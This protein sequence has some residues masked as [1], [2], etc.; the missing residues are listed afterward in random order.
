MAI[1]NNWCSANCPVDCDDTLVVVPD[2]GCEAPNNDEIDTIYWS[3]QI[4]SEGDV[5][6]WNERLDNSGTAEANTIRSMPVKGSL[7]RVDPAFKTSQLGTAIPMEVDRVMSFIVEDDKD[8]TFN[9]LKTIQCGMSKRF[10]LKSGGHMYGGLEG[11]VG[12]LVSSYEINPDAETMAHNWQVQL[13]FKSKCFPD[14]VA[15]PI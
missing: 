13:R 6:E 5:T 15:S 11:I 14:R 12:T 2:L 4:L 8:T 9:F 3:N 1:N 7:P 10:W